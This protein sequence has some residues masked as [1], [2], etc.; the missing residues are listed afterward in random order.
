MAGTRRDS[1]RRAGR[2]AS[3]AAFAFAL[4]AP[5]H[6]LGTLAEATA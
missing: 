4:A 6:R 3:G 1:R 5:W 2:I